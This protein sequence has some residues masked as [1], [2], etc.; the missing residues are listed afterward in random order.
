MQELHVAEQTGSVTDPRGQTRPP[1]RSV[2]TSLTPPA[3]AGTSPAAAL[4]A[5]RAVGLLLT[6]AATPRTLDSQ[7]IPVGTRP[8][9]DIPSPRATAGAVAVTK[10]ALRGRCSTAALR[11]GEALSLEPAPPALVEAPSGISTTVRLATGPSRPAVAV[12]AVGRPVTVARPADDAAGTNAPGTSRTAAGPRAET[13]TYVEPTALVAPLTV[14]PV[15]G[16]TTGVTIRP[17][18]KPLAFG[19]RA[20]AGQADANGPINGSD[21]GSVPS[22][23]QPGP[24]TTTTPVERGTR[25][26]TGPSTTP[27]LVG[28]F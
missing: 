10:R 16:A 13:T 1:G 8:R 21:F 26:T 17:T 20:V 22:V 15:A 24:Y 23:L 9:V 18:A 5:I 11:L 28:A 4:L 6:A 19:L 14:P 3:T 7:G 27:H 2:G 12:P 25:E